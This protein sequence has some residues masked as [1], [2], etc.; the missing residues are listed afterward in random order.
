MGTDLGT[1]RLPS[2]AGGSAGS[3][4]P[5]PAVSQ[6]IAPA[7][8]DP[9]GSPEGART[10]LDEEMENDICKVWDMSMDEVGAL[11]GA[12]ISGPVCPESSAGSGRRQ[13]IR[14]AR[15]ARSSGV[16]RAVVWRAA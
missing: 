2:G 11:C 6:V 13:G 1:Q 15:P 4:S 14:R 3:F 8:P 9:A 12:R 16:T 5:R 7:E 10:E